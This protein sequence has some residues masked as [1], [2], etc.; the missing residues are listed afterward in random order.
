[1]TEADYL[2][3]ITGSLG[4]LVPTSR[5][6]LNFINSKARGKGME[7]SLNKVQFLNKSE[8]STYTCMN[9][10]LMEFRK[11]LQDTKVKETDIEKLV[12]RATEILDKA[13]GD[14][15]RVYDEVRRY[16]I[17]SEIRTNCVEHNYRNIP[18]LNNKQNDLL[19]K[20]IFTLA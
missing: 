15:E 5:A 1:M 14:V 9:V 20:E 10:Q 17:T 4:K 16:I 19:A 11:H 12:D 3:P 7:L 18:S 13:R 8:K 2:R 6:L